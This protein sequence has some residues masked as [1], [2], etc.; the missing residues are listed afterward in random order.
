MSGLF[1]RWLG[2]QAIEPAEPAPQALGLQLWLDDQ[3]HVRRLAGPLRTLLPTSPHSAPR[4][5]DYL[6]RHSW[7]VLEGSPADWQ[8]QPL[9]LDFTTVHGAA[10]HTRGWLM[11]QADGW[12]LQL[13]DIGDL[14]AEREQQA[15]R[16]AQQQL[17]TEL[18]RALRDCDE[19]RLKQTAIEQLQHL[20]RYWHAGSLR[21]LLAGDHGWYTYASS[22]NSWPW[23]DDERLRAWLQTLPVTAWQVADEHPLLQSSSAGLPLLALPYLHGHGVQAWLLCA[24][25]PTPPASETLAPLLQAL[26]E[27]LLSRL[28]QQQL[29]QR[30]R[31]L[32]E[33]Q[34]QLGAGWWSW[35]LQGPME[36]DPALALRLG[37]PHKA[38]AEQWLGRLHPADREAA[39]MALE[40][41]RE[42]IA[43]NLHVRLQPTDNMATPHWLQW[44]GQLRGSLVQGF[45][46]DISAQK[47]QEAVAAAARARLENLIAS[48][49]AVI[50]IQRYNEGALHSE[51]F[52][53][54]LT[55]LLGWTKDSE[56]ARN[57]GLAVHHDDRP[58]WL[59]R[60]RTLLREGQVR[61]RYRL[62]D[63]QGGYHWILDEARLLRDDLG[64]PVE[65]VGLWLDVS[66]ATEASERVRQSEERYRVLVEDSPAMICRYTPDLQLLFGNRPLAELLECPPQQLC[67]MNL[68]QWMSDSQRTAFEQR[69]A[70]LTP[71]QPVS[72]AEVC[73]QLPGR[74]NAWWVWAER[75]LFDE[76]GQLLE[77]QAVGRDNTQVRHS[78]QQLLQGAKMAT[79]GELA[80]GM[81][82]EINQPL[83]TMRL[84]LVNTLKHLESGAADPQYLTGK[85]Q[86]LDTQLQR[87]VSLVEHLRT[88]GRRSEVEQQVFAAWVAVLGA[89][90]LLAEGLR[91]KGVA[92]YIEEPELCPEVRGHQ[93]QLE[94]VLINLMVNA[95]DA[96]LERRVAN[97]QIRVDQRIEQGQ[98]CL[99]V[100]D[101]GGG[102][103]PRLLDRIFEPF[104]TTKPAG[105]GTGLGLSV[106]HSIVEAM[107]GRLEAHNSDEGACFRVWLPVYSAS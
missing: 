18:G 107:G 38:T 86:R 1:D 14:L 75:G 52:S 47:A 95:R 25:A 20:A 87:A 48:S 76:Q 17:A 81:V 106:S 79:L 71:Q 35:P 59:E 102:I 63:Q 2:A 24:G 41:L 92:L 88:Y 65:A 105:M 97:P 70:T 94:Q 91:G 89:Q 100:Q 83:T 5:H 56:L 8:G 51:F 61:S 33:L 69:L 23:A 99:V 44:L 68:G 62:R 78:Q 13:F 3:G 67:E 58:L 77:V 73:L 103:D 40:Q 93:D 64:Q 39:R 27:P 43:L 7:L 32:E 60:T 96:L 10:L 19:Q 22:D 34:Q 54:S 36:F 11:Q 15:Q 16:L 37:V 29:Q 72:S 80:T 50:Y 90:W 55:P 104:F 30:S 28:R 66:E 101:N 31:H 12:L 82:H 53:A 46:L 9:D 84:V 57:P 49:P 74:R 45:V 21:L 26:V 85:L 98:L 6:Q 42:G 4:V